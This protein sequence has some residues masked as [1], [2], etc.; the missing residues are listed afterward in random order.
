[1]SVAVEPTAT[2]LLDNL[3]EMEQR[4][5]DY[6][7]AHPATGALKLGWRALAVR[8]C[9]HVV[10]GEHILELGAGS[11]LWTQHLTRVLRG[12]NPITAATFDESLT[13]AARSRRLQ[14]VSVVR[15][16]DFEA[17]LQPASFD[18]VVGTGIL[19]HNRFAE[20]VAALHRLLR[21]GGQLLFFETNFW[22]PLALLKRFLPGFGRWSGNASCQ[23]GLRKY[24][25]L[26]VCSQQG[27]SHLEIVPY[28]IIHPSIP[29]RLANFLQAKAIVL[30]Q[31]P[32]LRE[33]CGTLYIWARR[34]SETERERTLP[35]LAHHE[36]LR[37]EVSIVVPCHNE[38]MTVG[39]LVTALLQAYEPYVHDI[40][41]VNDNSTDRTSEALHAIAGHDPR[42]RVIDRRPPGGVGRALADGYAAASGTYILSM[43]CDFV[44]IVPELRDLFDVVSAGYDGAIGSRFSHES[45]L[46]NY[47][48]FKILCN[49]AFHL[50]VKLSL[51]PQVRDITNNLKLYR[52]EI[53]KEMVIEEPQ[54]AANAETGL[55]PLMAGYRIAE[56]PISWINRSVNMGTSSFR[57]ARVAPGYARALG[58][59]VRR[60]WQS[61][62]L[63]NRSQPV[64]NKRV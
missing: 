20:N 7:K 18:Y 33:L 32:L 59:V 11:G 16:R 63:L 40:V 49:R 12:E 50:L 3:R 47:P 51:L 44:L 19:C 21:P 42:V 39:R 52:A 57:I 46:I 45:I 54:F 60:A 22:N 64:A 37:G 5:E 36:S 29:E 26:K 41:L 38:E 28:D 30:E 24:Q 53:F 4:R 61:R 23:V 9:F 34:P 17:D 2:P 6:W 1:M 31:A 15:V 35:N 25:L 13:D 55:K 56:V 8:H 58:R 43:D 48:F 27:F 62:R 14:S 10:P